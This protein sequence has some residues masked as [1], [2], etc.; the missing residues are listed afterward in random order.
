M[1]MPTQRPELAGL[2]E[3][4]EVCFNAFGIG[5]SNR[6]VTVRESIVSR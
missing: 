6:E 3:R 2:R 5:P 4:F 1:R